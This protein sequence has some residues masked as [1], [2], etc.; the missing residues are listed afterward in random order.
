VE[1]TIS[2]KAKGVQRNPSTAALGT[3]QGSGTLPVPASL[4]LAPL[5]EMQDHIGLQY[6]VLKEL[7]AG[8]QVCIVAGTWERPQAR[9][10]IRQA[11]SRHGTVVRNFMLTNNTGRWM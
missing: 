10:V 5:R 11:M 8:I 7:V 9:R 4:L 2:D 3:A 1:E 6:E